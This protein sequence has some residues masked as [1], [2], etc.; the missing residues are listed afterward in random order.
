MK[1]DLEYLQPKLK[2]AASIFGNKLDHIL[3]LENEEITFDKFMKRAQF[4]FLI[5]EKEAL[6][7][8]KFIFEVENSN[9]TVD[10]NIEVKTDL[11]VFKL[12]CLIGNYNACSDEVIDNI[13]HEFIS[14]FK[15][16]K[17]YLF[18][19]IQVTIEINRSLLRI[20]DIFPVV[21]LFSQLISKMLSVTVQ[22]RLNLK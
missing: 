2:H 12:D 18:K 1:K 14:L 15:S 6:Q 20:L 4:V 3:E 22:F 8:S 7:L 17:A 10:R 19:Y 11:V 13:I 5:S 16:S 21:I 9:E